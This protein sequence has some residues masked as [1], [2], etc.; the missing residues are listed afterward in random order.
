MHPNMARLLG[1]HIKPVFHKPTWPTP[2]DI[3]YTPAPQEKQS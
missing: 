3:P 2:V 1:L